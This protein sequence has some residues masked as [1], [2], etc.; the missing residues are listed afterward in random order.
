MKCVEC[1]NTV[2]LKKGSVQVDIGLDKPIK[3]AG[4][5]HGECRRC[6][7]SYEFVPRYPELLRTIAEQV[8][9][10]PQRLTA[11]EIRFLRDVLDMKSKEVAERIAVDKTTYSKY[12]NA[13][14]VMD[15]SIERLFR[16]IVL[17]E[18]AGHHY[19][20]PKLTTKKPKAVKLTAQSRK[21]TWAVEASTEFSG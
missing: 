9:E 2:R 14:Q 15:T 6:G 1:G 21:G 17:A 5:E 8:A 18:L 16:F 11:K 20:V 19:D 10:K 4:V 7:E 3:V 13:K 12:E